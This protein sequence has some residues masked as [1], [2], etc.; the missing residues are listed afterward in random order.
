MRVRGLVEEGRSPACGQLGQRPMQL[1]QATLGRRQEDVLKP[2]RVPAEDADRGLRLDCLEHALLLAILLKEGLPVL[3]RVVLCARSC[4]EA[5]ILEENLL[6]RLQD[7]AVDEHLIKVLLKG[8]A[9]PVDGCVV[10]VVLLD[11]RDDI[12]R[13]ARLDHVLPSVDDRGRVLA[14]GGVREEATNLRAQHLDEAE[15]GRVNR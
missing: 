10:V 2:R 6:V 5:A 13:L 11:E 9:D 4:V 15:N 14:E 8:G 3:E 7:A 12:H 1:V